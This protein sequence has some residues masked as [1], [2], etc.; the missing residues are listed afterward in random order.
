[1]ADFV[2]Y[3]EDTKKFVV[4]ADGNAVL[5]DG[6]TVKVT[7]L[8]ETGKEI[9][10]QVRGFKPVSGNSKAL[11]L[12]LHTRDAAGNLIKDNQLED[13]KAVHVEITQPSSNG[14]KKAQADFILTDARKPEATSVVAQGLKTV[15]VKF[16]ESV[17]EADI[18]L[19]GD[20]TKIANVKFNDFNQATL[21]DER[22]TVTVTT[23]DYLTAGIHSVQL[24]N[25][26]DYAGLTDPKNISTNQTL[27]F[28]VEADPSVP[29]A[30]VSVESPEQFRIAFN[31][32][33]NDFDLSDVRLQKL[34]KGQNGAADQWVD[35]H[36]EHLVL[37][38]ATKPKSEYVLELTKD[39]TK[40]YD[41]SKNNTNYYNDQY[42]LVIAKESV[43]NPAN[44]KKNAEIILPLNF[45]GSALNTPDTASPVISGFEV[46]K[47][48]DAIKHFVVSMNEPVKLPNAATKDNAGNTAAQL[49]NPNE[50]D[51]D[52]GVPNPIIEFLGKDKDGN[53]VTIKG[54]VV[55]YTG[56]DKSDKKFIVNV[57]DDQRKL[58]DIVKAGGDKNWTLVVRSIS[59][60]VGNT[61]ASLT[62]N[63]K[64]DLAAATE[65]FMV[66]GSYQ[67]G[68]YNGVKGYLNGK[69]KDTI[70][71][72]FTADVQYTGT[73]EN[74]VNPSNYLLDGVK[75][76]EDTKLTVSDSDNIPGVDIVTITL[77]DGTLSAN[78]NNVITLSKSL[79]STKGTKLTGEYE[80]S[81]KAGLGV[82]PAD[83]DAAKAVDNQIAALPATITLADE[84][85]VVDARAEFDKLS[86]AQKALVKNIA[87]LEAAEK[88]IADLKKAEGDAAANLKAAQDA[89]KA[90]ETAVDADLTSEANLVAAEK[91]VAD[92]EAAV[93]KVAAGSDKEYLA[94]KVTVAKKTVADARTKFNG[95]A[96]A[97][98]KAAQDAVEALETAA[99]A[100]LT[101]ENNL[102]A[103]EDALDDAKAKVAKVAA[104]ADKTAL[105]E[106]VAAAE[107][108]VTDARKAFDDLA[109]AKTALNNAIE[110]AQ[111]KY[112]AANEGTN[113]GDYATGSKAEFKTA[114]DAAKSVL[115]D[116]A[117][118][119]GQ[120]DKAKE[121]LA[122]AE[123]TFD[124]KKIS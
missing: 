111:S 49:Q 98:L 110:A 46:V 19:D 92:A 43:T 113:P 51:A 60:D 59:D 18:Q 10:K 52:T 79:K 91:A 41:T 65:V 105:E 14:E 44:G 27:D 86:D 63:F 2:K 36:N 1:M 45:S 47:A 83:A 40:I 32:E 89:V 9:P 56:D 33:V 88:T 96:A 109:A 104:G 72:D 74:A 53:A 120:L 122:T 15:V 116:A 50:N 16:S 81:F 64:V 42:R 3:D 30:T 24:S 71:L 20:L 108:T 94:A 102:T 28:A 115:D 124:G 6:V 97:A 38:Q 69:G 84:Q 77:P 25:I 68:P 55:E 78:H 106:K 23:V 100:D 17:A 101:V 73:I 48:A 75:L 117:S 26:K 121:D 8:D 12:V 90:M 7:Q 80:I 54:K 103:A 123:A 119:K 99:K 114:I 93:A 85:K 57:A 82:E 37:E 35:A 76:P 87:T 61:A 66:K 11:E 21:E 58:E 107:K 118:T 5:N 39:W 62:Y 4:D 13:N 67:D 31:K 22:D 70:V 34:V 29:N 95:D 112:D